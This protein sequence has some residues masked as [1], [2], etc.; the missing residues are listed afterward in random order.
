MSTETA[1]TIEID[2]SVGDFAYPESHTFDAGYGLNR[3]TVNYISDV[4]NDP[5]WV[6]EFRLKAL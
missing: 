3:D 4:K 1:S 5:D 6:R 2:R